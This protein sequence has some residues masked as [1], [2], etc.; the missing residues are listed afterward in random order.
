MNISGSVLVKGANKQ[1][2]LSFKLQTYAVTF[3]ESNIPSEI[4]WTLVFNGNSYTL[5][6]TSYTFH[7]TNGSYKYTIST[8]DKIYKPSSFS[9][10]VKVNG[11]IHSNIQRN[12]IT[13]RNNMVC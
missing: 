6:N 12:R 13:S 1:I 11:I 7:V 2:N 8:T 9:G 4:S 10:L 5:T 3:T